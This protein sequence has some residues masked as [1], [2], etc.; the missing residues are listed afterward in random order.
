MKD[1]FNIIFLSAVV[2]TVLCGVLMGTIAIF[3]PNPQP[4]PIGALFETLK[5][6]FTVGM[7]S[8]FGLLGTIPKR[9]SQTKKDQIF[10]PTNNP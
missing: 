6:G 5:Y 1:R 9:Q 10:T 7:L 4:A 2:L 3:G 8:I